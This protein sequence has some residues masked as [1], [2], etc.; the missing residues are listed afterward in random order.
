MRAGKRE[1]GGFCAW[2]GS[3]RS[4]WVPVRAAGRSYVSEADT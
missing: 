2:R 1:L 3:E 4:M